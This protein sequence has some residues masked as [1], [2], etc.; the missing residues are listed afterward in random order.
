MLWG[1]QMPS[2]ACVPQT[3]DKRKQE[4]LGVPYTEAAPR[5]RHLHA[6]ARYSISSGTYPTLSAR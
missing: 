2:D 3:A 6:T 5:S 1:L 4:V